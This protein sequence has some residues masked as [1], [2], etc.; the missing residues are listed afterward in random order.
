MLA[1]RKAA[2]AA[3]ARAVPDVGEFVV[4]AEGGPIGMLPALDAGLVYGREVGEVD[5]GGVG[6][7]LSGPGS[8]TGIVHYRGSSPV[9]Q[10]VGSESRNTVLRIYVTRDGEYDCKSGSWVGAK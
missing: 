8:S 1:F 6:G 10:A 2:D 4:L 3:E 9:R 7:V 5:P